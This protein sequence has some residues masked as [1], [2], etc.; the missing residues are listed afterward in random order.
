MEDLILPP[1]HRVGDIVHAF[2]SQRMYKSSVLR[3]QRAG[4]T[5][6]YLVRCECCL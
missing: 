1:R 4:P 3:V 2:S 5:Y 6:C